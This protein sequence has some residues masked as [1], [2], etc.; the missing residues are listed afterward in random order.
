MNRAFQTALAV[1][2]AKLVFATAGYPLEI[3][4]LAEPAIRVDGNLSDWQNAVG[5]PALSERQFYGD[6]TEGDGAVEGPFDLELDV[7]VAIVRPNHVYFAFE[8]LDDRS[9]SETHPQS[10]SSHLWRDGQVEFLVDADRS[11]GAYVE[12]VGLQR[13]VVLP[14][15]ED[16]LAYAGA[17]GEVADAG[18]LDGIVVSDT[19][20]DGKLRTRVEGRFEV[21]DSQGRQATL[22]VGDTVGFAIVAADV[23]PAGVNV[24]LQ[25]IR[26]PGTPGRV[27]GLQ[28]NAEE[29]GRAVVSPRTETSV[30]PMSWGATKGAGR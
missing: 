25:V 23:D 11:G 8:R 12:D 30:V 5:E 13:V 2:T 14:F 17:A 18:S 19:L 7:W 29:L 15:V 1:T 4:L 3:P 6:P 20:A 21:F 10:G 16:V 22:A 9:T 27:L 28:Q 24:I 26:W